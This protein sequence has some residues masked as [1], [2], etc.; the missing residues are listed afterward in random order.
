[1][2]RVL[3]QKNKEPNLGGGGAGVE[4]KQNQRQRISNL[5]LVYFGFFLFFFSFFFSFWPI[6]TGL[7]SSGLVVLVGFNSFYETFTGLYRHY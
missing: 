7:T 6:L 4:P 2:A 1:M 3:T 5:E